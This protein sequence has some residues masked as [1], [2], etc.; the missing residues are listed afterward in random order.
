MIINTMIENTH[1]NKIEKINEIDCSEKFN[2]MK[3]IDFDD[4]LFDLSL[5]ITQPTKIIIKTAD[6]SNAKLLKA[7]YQNKYD[8]KYIYDFTVTGISAE[9]VKKE[10]NSFESGIK[11][12]LT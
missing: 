7:I 10:A 1:L 11:Y 4:Y 12:T 8:G 9:D 5:N 6:I 3:E 2:S